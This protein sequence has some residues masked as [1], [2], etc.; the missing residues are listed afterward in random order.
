MLIVGCGS[1]E[2]AALYV[3]ARN[4]TLTKGT[5]AFGS[6]LDGSVEIF[7]DLGAYTR[8][9]VTVEAISL[10]MYRDN[11]QIV[12]TAKFEPAA[13]TTFPFTLAPGS[14]QTIR[15]TV[16]RPQ[17]ID[18]EPADLCAGPLRITGTVK[19]SGQGELQVASE[20][21]TVSGC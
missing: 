20:S 10:G 8:G 21:V 13:G 5:N 2:D 12:P 17:L 7:F 4:P 14:R 3:Y 9:S 19:Q 11:K 18:A 15:Y 1:R 6:K 16:T